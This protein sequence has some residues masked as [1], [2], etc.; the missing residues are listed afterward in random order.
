MTLA[1]VIL[2]KTYL[3]CWV[4]VPVILTVFNINCKDIVF[5]SMQR[6]KGNCIQPNNSLFNI[7]KF[8]F[9]INESL[10]LS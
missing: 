9:L 2:L 7:W 1:C 10:L 3:V 5:Y 8:L 4:K 6:E